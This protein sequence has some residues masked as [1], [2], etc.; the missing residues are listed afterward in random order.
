MVDGCDPQGIQENDPREIRTRTPPGRDHLHAN[1]CQQQQRPLPTTTQVRHRPGTGG[2]GP[3]RHSPISRTSG[4]RIDGRNTVLSQRP[5]HRTGRSPTDVGTRHR[6][7]RRRLLHHR[8]LQ[9]RQAQHRCRGDPQ[10]VRK[11]K[12]QEGSRGK[13]TR[14]RRHLRRR[15]RVRGV[16]LPRGLRTGRQAHQR[17]FRSRSGPPGL[18]RLFQRISPRGMDGGIHGPPRWTGL[19]HQQGRQHGRAR[20]RRPVPVRTPRAGRFLFRKNIDARHRSQPLGAAS[21]PGPH[22]RGPLRVA[23]LYQQPNRDRARGD[24]HQGP[25]HGP[26]PPSDAPH[27]PAQGLQPPQEEA[28][29]RPGPNAAT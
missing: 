10:Q 16:L 23:P 12:K 13:S 5:T 4:P 26:A 8:P 11:T 27:Q 18:S 29:H 21:L 7:K 3:P 28:A 6:R 15:R 20:P 14:R 19:V 22:L 9:K 24:S 2:P 17:I 25:H 1:R